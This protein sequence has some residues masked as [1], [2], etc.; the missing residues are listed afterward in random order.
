M[1]HDPCQNLASSG[2]RYDQAEIN[3][4][5]SDGFGPGIT[6]ESLADS[7]LPRFRSLDMKLSIALG[8]MI[9]AANNQ[10][11]IDLATIEEKLIEEGSMLMGRQIAWKLYMYFHCNPIMDFT[12]GVRD[13]TVLPW[14]GDHNVANFL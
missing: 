9:K 13:L 14:Q 3:W 10:L 1:A 12:Y 11:S 4:F 5:I 2:G 7:G 8:K 6:F